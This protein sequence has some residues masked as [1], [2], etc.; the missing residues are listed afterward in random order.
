MP[1]ACRVVFVA[2]GAGDFQ[3]CSIHLKDLV[4]RDQIP[5]NVI[6]FDW[7]HG[8]GRILADQTHYRWAR[9]QG[10]RLADTILNYHARNPGTCIYLMGHSAGAAVVLAAVEELPAN[11]VDGIVLLAPSISAIY[12]LRPALCKVRCAIDVFHSRRDWLYLGMGTRLVGTLDKTRRVAAGRFGFRPVELGMGVGRQRA[13]DAC[14]LALYAKLRQHAWRPADLRL[15]NNGGHY[16][17]YQPG[18][19]RAYIVP[20]FLGAH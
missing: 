14:D 11:S 15:G 13:V 1:G 19:L 12:D 9:Q 5:L 20:N 10:S 4:L 17:G 2:D 6:T 18:Y 3:Q 8:Y 7:S 16:G